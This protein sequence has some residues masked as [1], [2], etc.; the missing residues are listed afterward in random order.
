MDIA[1]WWRVVRTR[2]SPLARGTPLGYDEVVERVTRALAWV[3][4][5][6]RFQL[7]ASFA[8]Y[9][10]V[11]DGTTW[12]GHHIALDFLLYAPASLADGAED[13]PEAHDDPELARELGPWLAIGA[14]S[15]KHQFWL[16]CDRARPECGRV[17]DAHDDHP[18]LNGTRHLANRGTFEQWLGSIA[19]R[20]GRPP[21][22]LLVGLTAEERVELDPV[23][24]DPWRLV[25]A[26]RDLAY[27]LRPDPAWRH[28]TG[29]PTRVLAVSHAPPLESLPA[30]DEATIAFVPAAD[31]HHFDHNTHN[32]GAWDA[33]GKFGFLADAREQLAALATAP[34]GILYVG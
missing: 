23:L 7:P 2:C 28:A 20:R 12:Y 11:L 33:T 10:A 16:C 14:W 9:L 24:D 13:D 1:A 34:G 8:D 27:V 22:G 32:L 18:Y 17:F 4:P 15:D 26:A 30:D 6:S 29:A 31:L 5:P 25:V 19:A 21:S 3:A